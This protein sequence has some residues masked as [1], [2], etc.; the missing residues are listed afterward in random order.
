VFT[1]YHDA[2]G[3]GSTRVPTSIDP[4]QPDSW[5]AKKRSTL[6]AALVLTAPGIPL[7][8]QGQEFLDQK[9]FLA[10]AEPPDWANVDTYAGILALY[11]DLI[12]LRRNWFD[13]TRGLRGEG[14]SV[15]HVNNTDKVIAF[16]RWEAGGVGDDVVVVLNF[17]NRGYPSYMVGLPGAGLWRVRLNSDWSG[18]DSSFGG[19]PS[20]DVIAGATPRDGCAYSGSIGLGPY[21]ALILSQDH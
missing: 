12:R 3:N 8:F 14:L 10:L 19:W 5:W 17:A 15:Y 6:G 2:D 4:G 11:R 20:D 9:P 21:T 13:T 16:H 7:L 1:E 18:Y